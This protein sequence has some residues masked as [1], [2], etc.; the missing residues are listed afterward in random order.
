MTQLDAYYDDIPYGWLNTVK[1]L[2]NQLVKQDE[3]YSV[4]DCFE[5]FGTMRV[6]LNYETSD[7][8][9]L[10]SQVEFYTSL[11]CRECGSPGKYC[12][13]DTDPREDATLCLDHLPEDWSY[14]GEE[15]YEQ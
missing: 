2:H 12:Y 11:H 3:N 13:K 10:I 14:L 6:Y 5:R 9:Q 8:L 15:K 1:N 4:V 7:I